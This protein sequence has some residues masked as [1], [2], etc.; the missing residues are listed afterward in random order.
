[1]REGRGFEGVRGFGGMYIDGAREF[2][3]PGTVQAVE[4]R[5]GVLRGL[6]FRVRHLD[7]VEEFVHKFSALREPFGK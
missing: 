4:L 7:G 3:T 1:M 6:G 2:C 5:V